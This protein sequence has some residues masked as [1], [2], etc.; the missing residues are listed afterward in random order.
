MMNHAEKHDLGKRTKA[1]GLRIVNLYVRLPRGRTPRGRVSEV[2]GHQAL[3]SGTSVGAHYR[4]GRRARSTAEFISKVETA[5]QELDETSYWLEMLI[6]SGI[7]K[8]KL[9]DGLL[10]ETN[11]L[12]KIFVKSVRTAKGEN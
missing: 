3:R 8:A 7:V 9:L 12:I 2:L 11:E 10:Q 1:Y 5:L 6:E 4:E